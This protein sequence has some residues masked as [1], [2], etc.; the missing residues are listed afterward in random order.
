[1]AAIDEDLRRRRA[2]AYENPRPEVQALVPASARRILDLGC[3]SGALGAAIK[4]RQPAEVIGI[5]IDPG[6]AADATARLDNVIVADLEHVVPDRLEIGRFDCL[7]AAD[8]LEH[9]RDPWT[10][11]AE[12]VRLLDPGGTAVVSL[13]NVR[14]WETFLQLGLHGTWPRRDEGIFDRSH[15][16]WFTRSDAIALME[17]AGLEVTRVEP[18]YRL[19][20]GDWRTE[21]QGRR[22]ARTPLAAFFVFQYVL[23]GVKRAPADA[24][25]PAEGRPAAALG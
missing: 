25:G 10:V 14:Y 17:Q 7:I 4:A 20:P 6:Y 23:A 15:L 5:E 21:V 3:S 19:R 11:L 12:T 22:F 2:G 18:R 16:R 13:P 9:L 24:P 8:V 1:M